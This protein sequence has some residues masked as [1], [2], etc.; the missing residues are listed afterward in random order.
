MKL[1]TGGSPKSQTT[2]NNLIEKQTGLRI[3][4][5]RW[6]LGMIIIMTALLAVDYWYYPYGT[7]A[8]GRSGNTGENG[9]WLRYTW[10]FGEH[11]SVDTDHLVDQFRQNQIMYA[12]FHVR[13]IQEDGSLKYKKPGVRTINQQLHRD[14]PLVKTFAWIYAGN[15][16]GLG[17][18]DLSNPRVRKRMVA[19][20]LWLVNNCGFDGIQWDYEICPNHDKGLIDLLQE[21]RAALPAGKMLSLCAPIWMPNGFFGWSDDYF[22]DIAPFCNQIT[23]MAYDTAAY[24]PRMYVGLMCRQ[25]IHVSSAVAISNPQCRVLFGI[26]TYGDGTPSHNPHAEN[27]EFALRGVRDGFQVESAHRSVIAGVSIFAD[28][29]TDAREWQI[30][31]R[32]WISH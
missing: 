18:V 4:R 16:K 22:R 15:S 9:L 7:Q 10:Y 26:P 25:V 11:T 24:L 12:Y 30:Y 28:Y 20:A 19:E 32:L 27:I 23:V 17:K 8:P 1:K 21:T 14:A 13:S 29:T 6:I 31:R 5:L 2:S 3:R